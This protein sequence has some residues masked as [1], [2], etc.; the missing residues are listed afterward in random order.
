MAK[1]LQP[2]IRMV[3]HVRDPSILSLLARRRNLSRHDAT[4][5]R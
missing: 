1:V 2:T 4:I 3:V 5:G